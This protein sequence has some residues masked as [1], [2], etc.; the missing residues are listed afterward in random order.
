MNS[1]H[2]NDN[3]Q[4]NKSNNNYS[5]SPTVHNMYTKNSTSGTHRHVV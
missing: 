2:F 3:N 1:K 5:N 4:N